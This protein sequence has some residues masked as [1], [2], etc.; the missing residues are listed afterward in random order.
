MSNYY[1]LTLGKVEQVLKTNIK[2]GLSRRTVE[3]KSLTL[4]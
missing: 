3:K 4:G 1:N 2:T